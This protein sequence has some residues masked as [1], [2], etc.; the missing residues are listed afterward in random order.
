MTIKRRFK[1]IGELPYG[2]PQD[3]FDIDPIFETKY[4]GIETEDLDGSKYVLMRGCLGLIT[5]DVVL[6]DGAFNT[7][8]A[9]TNLANL[10]QWQ[11]FAIYCGDFGK[12]ANNSSK[13]GYFLVK[14]NTSMRA[15]LATAAFAPVFM[16]L[17]P[18]L[19]DS[20]GAV[21]DYLSGLSVQSAESGGYCNVNIYSNSIGTPSGAVPAMSF[22]GTAV[23]PGV[24]LANSTTVLD[25]VPYA[26]PGTV[27]EMGATLPSFVPQHSWDILGNGNTLDT[28]NFLGTTNNQDVVFKRNNVEQLRLD[29]TEAKVSG[30]FHVTGNTVLDGNLDVKGLVTTIESVTVTVKDK[31]LELGSVAVPTNTTADGGGITLKG[32]TDKTINW[33]NADAH[34]HLSE[35]LSVDTGQIKSGTGTLNFNS[36]TVIGTGV[37]PITFNGVIQ[38]A[39]PLTFEGSTADTF[40]TAF[41]ITDPTANQTITFPDLTGTVLLDNTG[42][43]QNGNTVLSIKTLGTKDN[44]ALPIITNNTEK[45]RIDNATAKLTGK[46]NTTITTSNSGT[47]TIDTPLNENIFIGNGTLDKVIAIGNTVGVTALNLNAGTGNI[48]TAGNIIPTVDAVNDLGSLANRYKDIYA[49]T[50]YFIGT[51]V[52]T[53]GAGSPESVVI[54]NIGSFYTDN[55]NGAIYRKVSGVGNTG[56]EIVQTKNF[57]VGTTAGSNVAYTAVTGAKNSPLQT[58]DTFYAVFHT[59]SGVNA[60]LNINGTGAKQIRSST[61]LNVVANQ[62]QA[63]LKVA[64]FYD[65]VDYIATNLVT[66]DLTSYWGGLSTGTSIA[67]AITVPNKIG[68]LVAGEEY[69]FILHIT[70]GATP[71]LNVNGLGAFPLINPNGSAIDANTMV[72]NERVQ[73]FFDGT[74]F[75]ATTADGNAWLKN[76]NN[77]NSIK[78]LGTIDNFDLPFITNNTE[79]ARIKSTG[80]IVINS[81][82]LDVTNPERLIVEATNVNAIKGTGNINNYLQLNVKNRNTGV[83]ASSDIVATADTGTETTNFVD[84][85]INSSVYTGGIMG[86]ALD[87]YLYNLGGDLNIG[88]GTLTKKVNIYAGGT[89]STD[90]MLEMTTA[91]GGRAIT[92]KGA[93]STPNYIFTENLNDL[94]I[95]AQGVLNLSSTNGTDTNLGRNGLFARTTNVGADVTTSTLNLYG[96]TGRVNVISLLGATQP[97][98][99]TTN[100]VDS[101]DT[102]ITNTTPEGAITASVGDFA[103]DG[104]AGKAYLKNTGTAT[105][106][107]WAEFRTFKNGK[108]FTNTQTFVAGT[109]TTITHNL[110][111]T[112]GE[113][114]QILIEVRDSS[115]NLVDNQIATFIVNA[116]SITVPVNITNARVKIIRM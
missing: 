75:V 55:V 25:T 14:G 61:G 81:A 64:L 2:G 95:S 53:V 17:T 87:S 51:Q 26:L 73:T 44:F 92:F 6:Y 86:A 99:R 45:F 114:E 58:G 113:E 70:N 98:Y 31:N 72:T 78:N 109:A 19:I 103:T 29:N 97:I 82:T 52:F 56:W 90:K 9:Q 30:D 105:N 20:T 7:I 80:E 16:G 34:W 106:T 79:K 68:V 94:N 39:T 24:T 32:L 10:T 88:S 71:T 63:N 36:D 35:S 107:G 108:F 110:G 27:L 100:S 59:A 104:T 40:K 96:G 8:R 13:A 21:S 66:T 57:Y 112:V 54:A 91:G 49:T 69:E 111:L 84:M 4:L 38:G 22:I 89:A 77:V 48:N 46:G 3:T 93:A 28:V 101:I 1:G 11:G 18:G 5:G 50:N 83:I 62:I 12:E 115:G 116:V 37:N 33:L 102:F 85:G 23:F 47:L 76:G 15:P 43:A 60:T 42:W 41:A 65:G 67:Y 74:S